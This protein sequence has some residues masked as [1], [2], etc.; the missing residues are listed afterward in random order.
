MSEIDTWATRQRLI[1]ALARLHHA[2]VREL[3]LAQVGSPLTGTV[4]AAFADYL[5]VRD[6][7]ERAHEPATPGVGASSA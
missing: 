7:Y 1:K 5:G 2:A 6:D 4:P 3:D